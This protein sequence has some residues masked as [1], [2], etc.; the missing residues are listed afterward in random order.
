MS[1]S[2]LSPGDLASMSMSAPGDKRAKQVTTC[3]LARCP[4]T[5]ASSRAEGSIV[6]GFNPHGKLSELRP[7]FIKSSV[8]RLSGRGEPWSVF[9][10]VAEEEDLLPSSLG[11]P[12]WAGAWTQQQTLSLLSG[13]RSRR[14][15]LPLSAS[16]LSPCIPSSLLSSPGPTRAPP[17]QGAW[18]HRWPERSAEARE[19]QC[20]TITRQVAQEGT[21]GPGRLASFHGAPCSCPPSGQASTVPTLPRTPLSWPVSV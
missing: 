18:C 3:R 11:H 8:D 9:A 4:G 10:L 14:L 17:A 6:R 21:L 20:N 7:S 1:P 5:R 13:P 19:G 16:V 15:R 2:V 12:L